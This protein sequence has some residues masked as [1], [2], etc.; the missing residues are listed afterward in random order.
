MI[1]RT[2]DNDKRK[3]DINGVNKQ[4][5]IIQEACS[6]TLLNVMCYDYFQQN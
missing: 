2:L 5:L 3:D 1:V 4:G 6:F